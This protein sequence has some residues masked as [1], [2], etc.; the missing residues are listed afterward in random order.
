MVE[1]EGLIMA[2]LVL[3]YP[4][5]HEND[6]DSIQKFRK[7]HDELFYSRVLPHF[8]LVFPVSDMTE[9]DFKEE[10]QKRS[11]S[12][13][14]FPFTFRCA[15]LNKDSFNEY[16]H[17]FLVPDEGF[18]KVIRFH[19]TLYSGKLLEHR[20]LT[21]DFVPHMGIGCSKDPGECLKMI[22]LWN[23]RDFE[24]RG[25]VSVLDLVEFDGKTVKTF[26]QISL[27]Q[28]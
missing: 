17:V 16:Y 22:E 9:K 11:Q 1:L 13:S 6:L 3:A 21:I 14:S 5:L 26:E 4:E 7:E 24:I 10:I 15:V 19:D 2:R 23:Q 28:P 18:S 12:L 8:T 20:L 25:K 27:N